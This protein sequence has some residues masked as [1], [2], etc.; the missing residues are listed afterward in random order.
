MKRNR[1]GTARSKELLENY[2]TEIQSYHIVDAE[3]RSQVN[4]LIQRI[5]LSIKHAEEELELMEQDRQHQLAQYRNAVMELKKEAQQ[6]QQLLESD[7]DQQTQD[8]INQVHQQQHQ[9]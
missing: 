3:E 1:T 4:M 5:Q 7:L 8:I 2:I 9:T 6:A